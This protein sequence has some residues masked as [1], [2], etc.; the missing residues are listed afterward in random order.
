MDI[1][2]E[3]RIFHLF[4]LDDDIEATSPDGG[5]LPHDDIL[6]DAFHLILFGKKCGFEEH[7]NGFLKIW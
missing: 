6:A 3:F 1:R 5:E 7:F 4:L 2:L